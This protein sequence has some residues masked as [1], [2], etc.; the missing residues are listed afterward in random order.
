MDELKRVVYFH[1]WHIDILAVR[2]GNRLTIGLYFDERRATLTFA[3]TS[4]SAVEHFGLVNIVYEIKIL[5]PEDTRYEKALAVL[6]K[7]DRYSPKQGRYIALVAATA[8]A[9][10]VIEFESLEIEAT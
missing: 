3:G 6:E 1:D 5:Q 7:A 4:R 8:G 9:E 2:Q 10:L